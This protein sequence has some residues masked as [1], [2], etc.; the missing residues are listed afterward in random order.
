MLKLTGF[1]HCR[2]TCVSRKRDPYAFVYGFFNA[3]KKNRTPNQ[4]AMMTGKKLQHIA[5]VNP[6]VNSTDYRNWI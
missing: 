4:F 3:I 2:F 5:H 6:T 1:Y